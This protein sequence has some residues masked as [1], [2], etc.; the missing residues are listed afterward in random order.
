MTLDGDH[1]PADRCLL[2]GRGV[3]GG[4]AEGVK[5]AGTRVR[6]VGSCDLYGEFLRL[7]MRG[8]RRLRVLVASSRALSTR[9]RMKQRLRSLG[10]AGG[11]GP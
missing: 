8:L 1:R 11:E 3:G 9:T 2:S 6:A 7:T 5:S 10:R 4:A